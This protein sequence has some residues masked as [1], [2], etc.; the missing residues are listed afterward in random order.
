MIEKTIF[1]YLS[2]E[3]APIKVYTEK[4]SPMPKKFVFFEKTGSSRLNRIETA[5]FIFQSYDESL[6]QTAELNELVKEKID[7]LVVLDEIGSS[8]LQSDYPFTDVSSKRHRYQSLY[9]ITY[10]IR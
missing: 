6:M 9:E 4:P 1:D 3:L 10:P 8:R 2:E 7:N 5:T